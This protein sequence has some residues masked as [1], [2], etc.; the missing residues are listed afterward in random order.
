MARPKFMKGVVVG[1]GLCLAASVAHPVLYSLFPWS[2]AS[3]L[4]TALVCGGYV[5]FLLSQTAHPSG[6][7]TTAVLWLVLAATG[8]LFGWPPYLYLISQLFAIW[9]IRALYF[10]SSVLT[11]GA[12]LGLVVV[13]AGAAFWAFLHTGSL[14]LTLWC[15]F[16]VQALF[17]LVPSWW[18][19]RTHSD[20]SASPTPDNFDQARRQ[21]E[22]ALNQL[23]TR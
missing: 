18:R 14:F 19:R 2:T 22:A 16:L 5:T 3:R 17:A 20:L 7:I 15:F 1:L 10:H 23:V 21:A 4:L 11:A 9:L 6:R 8:G 12:D 13:G